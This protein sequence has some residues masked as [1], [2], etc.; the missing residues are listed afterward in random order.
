AMKAA[1]VSA[2]ANG[3]DV[4]F[5]CANPPGYVKWRELAIPMLEN[6]IA[7]AK[8]SDA[9]LIFPG[10]IY[11]FGPDSWPLLGESTPQHPKTRK[12]AVRVEMEAMLA[13]ASRQGLR[14]L[15]VRAGDFLGPSSGSWFA[16]VMVKPG[17]PLRAVT[18][19]GRRDIGHAW[20]YLPDLAE[21]I[22]RLAEIEATLPAFDTFNFGG[23]WV[24]PGVEIA[25]AVRRAS[26]K[27]DLPIRRFPWPLVHL[28]APFS[29]FMRELVEMRYLWREP[30]RLDNRKLATLLGEE[31]HTLLDEAVRRTL[32][33]L[34]CLPTTAPERRSPA[35]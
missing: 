10:N 26:G 35:G 13:E 8:A 16:A 31:P 29:P 24:E 25:L 11:N 20:A 28:A 2:A 21:A 19:P 17:K 32:V 4:I 27:P 22:A 6:A 18:Y 1:D 7:A 30:I 12:G 15:V 3:A 9:R 23:H 5:H 34:G 33:A 14:A